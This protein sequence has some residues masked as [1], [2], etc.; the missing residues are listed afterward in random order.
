MTLRRLP[1]TICLEVGGNALHQDVDLTEREREVLSLLIQGHETKSIATVLG[2]SIHAV[3]ER[4]RDARRK[5]G[6]SS[7]REAARR[8]FENTETAEQISRDRKIGI[9][10]TNPT[11]MM[12]AV[13]STG[14]TQNRFVLIIVGVAL[15]LSIVAIAT[16]LSLGSQSPKSLEPSVVST[17]P[18]AGSVIAPGP[19]TLSVTFDRPMHEESYS[20]VQVS[21]DS[22]P[23]CDHKAQLSADHRTYSM[24]CFAEGGKHYEVWFNR[25]PY[26][27][28]RAEDGTLAK[29]F[30]LL[31]EVR[32]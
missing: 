15:M 5:L 8:Y 20:F 7:S 12:A 21:A 27:A 28:F 13:P 1:S 16:A 4:L 19:F 29:P 24:N 25:E 3:N 9:G 17:T 26:L 2:I 10:G 22:F 30:R 23:R 31:F 32:K 14:V 11:V 6:A 18:K